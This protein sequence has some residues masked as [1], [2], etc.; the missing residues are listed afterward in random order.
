M[1]EATGASFLR[2]FISYRRDETQYPAAWLYDRLVAHFGK[3]QIFKDIDSIEPGD[4]FVEIITTAVTSCDVLLALIGKRWLTI[5]D[6]NKNR[7][8][9]DPDDF[10]RLEIE[11]ALRRN[12]LVIPIL[13]EDARMPKAGDLPSSLV[14]L[15][16]RQSLELSSHH[17]SYD[18]TKLL[19][20]LN[21]SMAK[22]QAKPGA[23]EKTG[24]AFGS[25]R[26]V[27]D[28][29]V[30]LG[31]LL[32]PQTGDASDQL[33]IDVNRSIARSEASKRT[34]G[35]AGSQRAVFDKNVDLAPQTEGASDGL[36]IHIKV[37]RRH[38]RV[39]E[40][41]ATV[42]QSPDYKKS[43]RG[44]NPRDAHI[45]IQQI[46]P[47]NDNAAVTCSVEC[48][49][50]AYGIVPSRLNQWMA[51]LTEAAQHMFCQAL[52]REHM[53]GDDFCEK[54]V[55]ATNPNVLDLANRT[56]SPQAEAH[57]YEY[58]GDLMRALNPLSGEFYQESQR[59]NRYA[60][61]LFI[62][63]GEWRGNESAPP[64][65]QYIREYSDWLTR[66]CDFIKRMVPLYDDLFDFYYDA[67]PG[68]EEVGRR[69]VLVGTWGCFNDP[70][71]CDFNYHNMTNW[72]RKRFVSPGVVI[73]G[74][75]VT[76]D[77]IKMNLGIRVLLGGS[78]YENWQGQDVFVTHDPLGNPVDWRHPWNQHTILPMAPQNPDFNGKYSWM[79]SPRWFDGRDHLTLETGALARLWPTALA[80]LVD[81]GT[82]KAT[83][84]SVLI[85]LPKTT[86]KPEVTFEWKIP[87]DRVS[88]PLSNAIE[89]NRARVYFHA[90][91]AAVS[92]YF[93]ERAL[94][95]AQVDTPLSRPRP[96]ITW[97]LKESVKESVGCGFTEAARGA[98]CHHLV[99][100]RGKIANYSI[101][102]PTA[103]TVGP[104]DLY[105]TPGPCEDAV[106][107]TQIFEENSSANFRGIDFKRAA[108]SF[109][110]DLTG[111]SIFPT[112][113]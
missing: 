93:I 56:R 61:E 43:L 89:R 52:T 76:N 79:M 100:R 74:K 25:Q 10:V 58:I 112:L 2:I 84:R 91:S 66:H 103:W 41:Y 30:N 46:S 7:R 69:R 99:I 82:V 39:A 107:N 109:A 87:Y 72:G 38:L 15:A 81:C 55:G 33:S 31:D 26:A 102:S 19:K 22:R 65:A 6:E 23:S 85:N 29:D 90:Y 80:G 104:R 21:R 50:M 60:R 1:S 113:I 110:P 34:E 53:L 78:F 63:R 12:V 27:A 77:L 108:R 28:R 51:N 16:R 88:K 68:Y 44:G 92:L 49:N 45:I 37:D 97:R 17:F 75:L 8:L 96:R 62:V 14:N 95:E 36:G 111:V 3:D 101:L 106:Q 11:T 59:A 94:A 48:Q 13:V 64:S 54:V 83:G 20:V 42:P 86:T 9:D 40:C 57:G 4:D 70:E 67:M 105:G 35:A 32:K 24:M 5:V 18:L 73:D 71:H 47:D 98:L